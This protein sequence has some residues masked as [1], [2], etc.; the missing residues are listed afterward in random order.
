MVANTTYYDLIVIVTLNHFRIMTLVE[1]QHT[2]TD[3]LFV[4]DERASIRDGLIF[5]GGG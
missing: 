2:G 1:G 4:D 3:T 5:F